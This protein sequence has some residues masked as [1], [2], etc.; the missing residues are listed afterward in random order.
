MKMHKTE[1]QII[2][3]TCT[4]KMEC[5][6]NWATHML[7]YNNEMRSQQKLTAP[8]IYVYNFL[9]SG[10]AGESTE[11]QHIIC[12]YVPQRTLLKI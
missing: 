4:E 5:S 6:A 9:S 1:M 8:Y 7:P 3:I 12:K 2:K 11:L 10:M